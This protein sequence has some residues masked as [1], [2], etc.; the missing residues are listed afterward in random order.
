MNDDDIRT[1]AEAQ[2]GVALPRAGAAIHADPNAPASAEQ[3]P[4]PEA[5]SARPEADKSP[6]E[7]AY[8]RLILYIQN[9]EEHLDS[10]E[11]IAMGMTDGGAGLLKIEGIGFF[12]P[13]IVSFYGRDTDGR[14]MQLVQ[15]V[16][17][18]NVTLRALPKPKGEAP[19]QRIGFH[20]A[21]GLDAA[22]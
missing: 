21:K 22:E 1:M 13:D 19:A 8:E 7:W 16:T 11:E 5:V 17:Q 10:E 9:F 12:A 4:L 6:A 3:K 2:E 18:L 20:L 14:R 15:H